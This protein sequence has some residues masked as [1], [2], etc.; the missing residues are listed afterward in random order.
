MHIDV[1]GLKNG[2]LNKGIDPRT[3]QQACNVD[4]DG[5]RIE[6]QQVGVFH[7][8]TTACKQLLTH[9]FRGLLLPLRE[10]TLEMRCT[11]LLTF[12]VVGVIII[13]RARKE[14]TFWQILIDLT[15]LLVVVEFTPFLT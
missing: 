7:Q 5:A 3:I 10:E 6:R 8:R 12:A 13:E 2:Q 9:G 14:I 4:R 1:H 15:L 11:L